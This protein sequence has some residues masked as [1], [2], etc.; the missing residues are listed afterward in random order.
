ML[1]QKKCTEP[2]PP[3]L[4]EGHGVLIKPFQNRKIG[5]A[6]RSLD[7]TNLK[8]NFLEYKIKQSEKERFLQ[9]YQELCQNSQRFLDLI[10]QLL[11]NDPTLAVRHFYSDLMFQQNIMET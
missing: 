10:S 11:G 4:Y 6:K 9:V 5:R 1:T 7:P 8:L 2:T 3:S